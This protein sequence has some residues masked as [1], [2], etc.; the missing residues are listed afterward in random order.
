MR[1]WRIPGMPARCSAFLSRILKRISGYDG[2]RSLNGW[3]WC[4]RL[5]D[6]QTGWVPL[7]LLH[8]HEGKT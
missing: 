3:M 5:S 2:L 4:E 6:G 8:K 7:A 1:L